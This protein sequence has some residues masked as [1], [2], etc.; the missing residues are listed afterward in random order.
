MSLHNFC[1]GVKRRDFL[2]V[3]ALSGFGLGLSN[4]FQLAQAGQVN[5]K[6]K[7]KAAIYIRLAGGPTHM[8]TFD[9]KPDAPV[10]YRGELKPIHTNVSGVEISEKLPLL[11]KIA[12]KYA[13]L[14]GVSHTLAA[15]ELG[16]KYTLTGNR[17]LPSLE[18]PAL[19]SIVAKELPTAS[20]M[21]PYVAIPNVQQGAGY[22]GLQYGPLSTNSVP[23]LGEGYSVRG[24]SLSGSMT[25]AD[26]ARRERLLSSVD[27][28][29][30]SIE[31]NSDIL[32]GLDQFS[33]QAYN[34]ISSKRAREA[35]DISKESTKLR[36]KFGE[37]EVGQS[38]LLALRL[39]ESGVRFV[40]IS[41]GGWDM[42]ADI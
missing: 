35:F 16:T 26:V 13:V 4:Y 18:Y 11:A 28:T 22:L 17:P 20:D 21:P 38:A 14:R 7:G 8:D 40:T 5:A 24:L 23:K 30:R 29:F 15:H 12:D 19:G 10:E 25:L 27:T 31:K 32:S 33:E 3:G 37:G 41:T 6:A 34:M 2:R 36:E 1:D 42:H 39:V 9:L